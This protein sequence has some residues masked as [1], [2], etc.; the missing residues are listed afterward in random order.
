MNIKRQSAGNGAKIPTTAII[1]GFATGMM[2][3]CIPIID[4]TEDAIILPLAIVLGATGCTIAVWLSGTRQ[5]GEIDEL[6]DK[7][8][9]I[10][11]RVTDLETI[12]SV[13]ELELSK[14][15]EQLKPKDRHRS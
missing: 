9:V 11:E 1:W 13:Q 5:R 12:C 15:F 3:I 4:M 7:F 10:Q 14:K 2:A 6:T 8:R